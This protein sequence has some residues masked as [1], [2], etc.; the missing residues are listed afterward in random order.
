VALK[1]HSAMALIDFYQLAVL[2]KLSRDDGTVLSKPSNPPLMPATRSSALSSSVRFAP[3]TR[4]EPKT[5]QHKPD[6]THS[7]P[8]STPMA[9]GTTVLPKLG[10]DTDKPKKY[11]CDKYEQYIAQDFERHRVFV[12]IDVFMKHVLHVPEN[13]EELWGRTIRQIKR[14]RDF[15]KAIWDYTRH[16]GTQGVQE[17]TFYQPLVHIANT[18]LKISSS[19]SS[20]LTKPLTPQRYLRNDPRNVSC[21]MMNDLSPD[22]VAVH[23][24][25]LDS[26]Q[27]DEKV[28]DKL[29][30]S[31]ITWAQPLQVLEVKPWDNALVDGSCMPMLKADGESVGASRDVLVKLIGNRARPT[32]EPCPRLHA[33]TASEEKDSSSGYLPIWRR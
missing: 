2:H 9:A 19:S 14:D 13:W 8:F 6:A 18:I 21:G 5:P 23:Q 20:D 7:A 15:A 25:S 31:N 30:F 1:H 4:L 32:R 10:A 24:E 29:Q 22:L 3:T 11:N 12:D 28:E 26:F 33:I 16:C 17:Q 27:P